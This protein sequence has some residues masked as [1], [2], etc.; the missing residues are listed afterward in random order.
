MSQ[1]TSEA[2]QAVLEALGRRD[3]AGLIALSDPQVEWHSFFAIGQEGGVYCGYA[4]ASQF[5]SDL[6]D[7]WDIARAEV[8]DSIEVGD[9]VVL[10]GRIHYRGR[11]GG[12]ESEMPAGWMLKFRQGRLILFRAF[13]EPERAFESVGLSG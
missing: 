8:D 4:G 6:G 3:A 5:M 1:E 7:A 11:G 13:R 2:A 9:L 12:V 10:A